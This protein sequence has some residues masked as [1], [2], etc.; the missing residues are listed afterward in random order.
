MEGSSGIQVMAFRGS[1]R[2]V[3]QKH[4]PSEGRPAGFCI[5]HLPDHRLP[6]VPCNSLSLKLGVL[7]KQ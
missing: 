6:G 2:P 3:T 4:P 5:R 1:C 7:F